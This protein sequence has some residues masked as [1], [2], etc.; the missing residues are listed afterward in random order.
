MAQVWRSSHIS[1]PILPDLCK[2]GGKLSEDI[3][4]CYEPIVTD[5]KPAPVSANM[6]VIQNVSLAK[7]TNL[8]CSGMCFCQ[9]YENQPIFSEELFLNF[10]GLLKKLH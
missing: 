10:P 1:K 4:N 2:F 3:E 6:D 7:K 9:D 5:Q 8:I